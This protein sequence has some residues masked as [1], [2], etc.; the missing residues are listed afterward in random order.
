M[1]LSKDNSALWADIQTLY[2][3]LTAQR[4]RLGAAQS[5]IPASRVGSNI[6]DSDPNSLVDEITAL[7]SNT[8][9]SQA[10]VDMSNLVKVTKDTIIT[11]NPYEQVKIVEDKLGDVC[12]HNSSDFSSNFG[13]NQSYFSSDFAYNQTFFASLNSYNQSLFS[14]LNS[15][16]QSNFTSR[17]TYNSSNYSFGR[18]GNSGNVSFRSSG[19]VYG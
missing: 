15:Y 13:Y 5:P 7:R 9:V 19:A 8:Y 14:S 6:L 2:E 11:A 18:S 17:N 1:V 3:E 4:T 10:G 12:P 16:N